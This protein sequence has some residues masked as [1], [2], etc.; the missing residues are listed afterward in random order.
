MMVGKTQLPEDQFHLGS[1][2]IRI[3]L[4]Q[5]KGSLQYTKHTLPSKRLNNQLQTYDLI[6]KLRNN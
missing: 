5:A 6:V 1:D 3:K 4:S 2:E